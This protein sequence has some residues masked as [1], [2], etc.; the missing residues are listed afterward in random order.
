MT[1]IGNNYAGGCIDPA[2]TS[3]CSRF[4]SQDWSN[5][6]DLIGISAEHIYVNAGVLVLNLKQI[7]RDK[8]V[9]ELFAFCENTR[10]WSLMGLSDQDAINYV[11]RGRIHCFDSKYNFQFG[12]GLL[13]QRER[14][15]NRGT[16][17]VPAIVHFT[18]ADKPWH[19]AKCLHLFAFL[20]HQY[21]RMYAIQRENGEMN[22]ITNLSDFA[23]ASAVVQSNTMVCSEGLQ[24]AWIS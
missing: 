20:Y 13:L 4:Y 2:T 18:S 9:P 7:R 1:D 6:K 22:L 10:N 14:R 8:K 19:G 11:F 15:Y 5:R 23:D 21:A 12:N 17:Q 24:T 16:V 3:E